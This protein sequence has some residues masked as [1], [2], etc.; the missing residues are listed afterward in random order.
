MINLFIGSSD[1]FIWDHIWEFNPY[2]LHK[3]KKFLVNEARRMDKLSADGS[4]RDVHLWN[5]RESQFLTL[6]SYLESYWLI[7]GKPGGYLKYFQ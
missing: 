4:T 2:V 3:I 1:F 5:G 7:L 6:S